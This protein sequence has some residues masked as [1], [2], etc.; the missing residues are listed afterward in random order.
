MDI[1][2]KNLKQINCPHAPPR[3]SAGGTIF[4]ARKKLKDWTCL[5]YFSRSELTPAHAD[6]LI[7]LDN[8]GSDDEV[9]LLA[10]FSL[11]DPDL[12]ER[13]PGKAEQYFIENSK[14]NVQDENCSAPG[15]ELG[16]VDTGDPKTLE[17]FLLWGIKNYPAR[18]FMA[19]LSGHG[20]G[21]L[22]SMDDDVTENYISN[23]ELAKVL[24]NIYK[25]T[26]VKIDIIAFNA[27][28]MNQ[29]EVAYEL[30]DK[31]KI[32]IGSEEKEKGDGA[33]LRLIVNELKNETSGSKI[34]SPQELAKLYVK[35]CKEA[36]YSSIY[37]PT[38]SALDLSKIEALKESVNNL[39]EI[40]IDKDIPKNIMQNIIKK[41]QHY[42]HEKPFCDFRDLY[43]FAERL[44]EEP[45]ITDR[46]I[47]NAA[48][49]VIET[50]NNTI[51]AEQH[52]SDKVSGSHG[53]S[54]YLPCDFPDNSD[55]FP[56][57]SQIYQKTNFAKETLWDEF[58]R[59]YS[60]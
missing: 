2:D 10:H 21:F 23:Q 43:D 4:K 19:V 44:I 14:K 20:E 3:L 32:M 38:Q 48:Q 8:S 57:G 24:E 11:Y 31:V 50:V 52:A 36:N 51:I 5:F 46:E 26:G 30:K 35:K 34:V 16:E 59:K 29:T 55:N 18:H 42:D 28:L 12:K 47:K 39:A 9:N 40:L 49:A 7:G 41:T 1:K 25:D 17:N 58:L 6:I 54:V 60:S 33:P 56:D 15:E 37:T 13:F 53:I 27:C 22:G 45:A